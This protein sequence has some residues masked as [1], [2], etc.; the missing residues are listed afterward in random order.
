MRAGRRSLLRNNF[1]YK[2]VNPHI[3]IQKKANLTLRN[4]ALAAWP[5][6]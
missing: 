6:P 3:T 4:L 2:K 1:E 5:R